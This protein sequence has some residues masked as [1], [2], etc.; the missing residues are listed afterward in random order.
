MVVLT[1]TSPS[2]LE[3]Y[4][5]YIG[6]VFWHSRVQSDEIDWAVGGFDIER[7]QPISV[8]ETGPYVGSQLKPKSRKLCQ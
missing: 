3:H 7:Q 4:L 1:R 5:M 8:A 2:V 6:N